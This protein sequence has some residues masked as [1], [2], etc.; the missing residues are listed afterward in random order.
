MTLTFEILDEDDN[1]VSTDDYTTTGTKS[2]E[3][4]YLEP[5]QTYR[6]RFCANATGATNELEVNGVELY[7]F[8]G[9]RSNTFK[10]IT[11]TTDTILLEATNDEQ[12]FSFHYDDTFTFNLRLDAELQQ[13]EDEVEVEIIRSGA[14]IRTTA[15]A[16]AIEIIDLAINPVPAYIHRAIGTMRLHDDFTLD[17]VEYIT[18]DENYDIRYRDNSNLSA[19]MLRLTLAEENRTNRLT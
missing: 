4:V 18:Y 13:P 1:V 9:L 7:V 14:G 10:R 12:A 3:V 16:D 15:F 5:N 6:I 11:D 19:A 2:Y 17:G 8:E